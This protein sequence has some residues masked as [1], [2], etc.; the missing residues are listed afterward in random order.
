METTPVRALLNR[1]ERLERRLNLNQNLESDE[2]SVL[3]RWKRIQQQ[4]AQLQ[5]LWN[6]SPSSQADWAWLLKS[7]HP[8]ITRNRRVPFDP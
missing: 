7:N 3:Q 6:S 1:V 4:W 2:I 8:G 5:P